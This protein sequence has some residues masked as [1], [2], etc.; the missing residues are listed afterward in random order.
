MSTRPRTNAGTA[1]NCCQSEQPVPDQQCQYQ[2]H[3]PLPTTVVTRGLAHC[4]TVPLGA[5]SDVST[6][7]HDTHHRLAPTHRLALSRAFRLHSLL[8]LAALAKL[9]RN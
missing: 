7:C 4:T 8:G 5:A 1:F 2:S 3:H 6:N 9:L